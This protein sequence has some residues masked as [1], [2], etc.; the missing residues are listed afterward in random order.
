MI[1]SAL[2]TPIV[3]ALELSKGPIIY[4]LQKCDFLVIFPINP[5]HLSHNIE[6]PLAPVVTKTIRRMLSLPLI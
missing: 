6:M 1:S 2:V 5:V 4:A 3:I